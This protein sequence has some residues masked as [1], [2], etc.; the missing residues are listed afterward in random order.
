[1]SEA[2]QAVTDSNFEAAVL[3][4]DIPVLVDFWAAW[5]M[6]C[7]QIAPLLDSTAPEYQ[8]RVKFVKLDVTD[9]QGTAAR[10]NVRSIPTLMIFKDGK[11]VATHI[12]GG[13]AKSTL[14]NFI[15][16]NL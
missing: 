2:L 6:P 16:S 10:Y 12:G 3:K 13:F 4:S 15:D 7:K 11:A 1:M 5:C 8:G 9:N 14:T